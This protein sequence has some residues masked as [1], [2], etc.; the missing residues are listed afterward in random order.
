MAARS[1]GARLGF[2]HGALS[3]EPDCA[4]AGGATRLAIRILNTSRLIGRRQRDKFM[5]LLLMSSG[6][7]DGRT[8]FQKGFAK[9]SWIL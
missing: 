1:S 9:L 2:I 3:G 8:V 7:W 5:V 6:R 4:V